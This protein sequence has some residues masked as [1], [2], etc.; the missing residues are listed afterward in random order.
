MKKGK[1]GKIIV[2]VCV[3]GS[4][5]ACGSNSQ[6]GTAQTEE[7]AV[8]ESAAESETAGIKE[9]VAEGT[10]EKATESESTVSETETKSASETVSAE[11]FEKT[12]DEIFNKLSEAG[13]FEDSVEKVDSSFVEMLL[14]ISS[15]NYESACLYVGS[16]ATAERL[17]VFC[18]G[19]NGTQALLDEINT[20]LET[21]KN[22]YAGYD[23]EEVKN[24][25]NAV[26]IDNGDTVVLCIAADYENAA[27]ILNE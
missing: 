21:I 24:I 4:L 18:A 17:A 14:N 7:I 13:V 6:A 1:L 8:T 9:S 25:E 27:K 22:D 5:A 19:E 23:P 10:A 2:G 20:H 12:C 16:G 26:V 15:E 3:V 11:D